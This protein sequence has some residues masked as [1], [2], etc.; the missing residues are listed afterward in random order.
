MLGIYIPAKNRTNVQ[1]DKACVR[2]GDL[3]KHLEMHA[4]NSYQCDVCQKYFSTEEK[5]KAHSLK[6]HIK[7]N[8]EGNNPYKCDNCDK[9]FK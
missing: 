8:P 4:R 5:L 2:K 9:S 6:I 7:T 3:D 1:C